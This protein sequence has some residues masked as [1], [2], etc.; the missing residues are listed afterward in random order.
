LH[1]VDSSIKAQGAA[2]DNLLQRRSSLARVGKLKFVEGN[3]EGGRYIQKNGGSHNP[4]KK[5]KSESGEINMGVE[6]RLEGHPEDLEEK[7]ISPKT[8]GVQRKRWN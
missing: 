8:Y 5:R 6:R 3:L 7:N 4:S 1:N 2:S